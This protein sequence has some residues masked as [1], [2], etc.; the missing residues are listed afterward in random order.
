MNEAYRAMLDR[1]VKETEE[2]GFLP[3]T[4]TGV[5]LL[6]DI[7]DR[8]DKAGRGLLLSEMDRNIIDIMFHD[9]AGL[10]DFKGPIM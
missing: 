8:Y 9:A 2:R 4:I 10:L 6:M 1:I 5:H 7:L 3:S